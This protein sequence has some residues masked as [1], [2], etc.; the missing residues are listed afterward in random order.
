MN[1]PSPSG[2]SAIA[3]T[4]F[5]T[6]RRLPGS[7]KDAEMASPVTPSQTIG[8][9]YG[10]ALPFP[11]G[12]D[13]APA[14]HPGAV[15]IHGVVYDGAGQPVPDAMLEFWQAAPD[16]SRSGRPGSLR[17]DPVTGAFLGRRSMDF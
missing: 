16:G 8:P 1:C 13:I 3:G 7:R 9:F 12:G 5:W 6:V 2:R 15:T 11:S 14:G 17:R 4:S 10:Y